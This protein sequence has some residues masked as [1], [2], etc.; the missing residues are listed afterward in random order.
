M[1]EFPFDPK[2]NLIVVPVEVHGES[3]LVTLNMAVDTG[4]TWTIL[5]I[6]TCSIIGAVHQRRISIVTG[7]RVESAHLMT[8]P[9]I[10]AFGINVTNFKVVAHDLPS[11]L[12]VDGLLGMNFLKRVK[13][14]IDFHKN[15][16]KIP[17]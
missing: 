6:K 12:L 5:P 1:I 7:S 15:V 4:A 8:I 2:D 14:T 16:I 17:R 9:L 3:Q 10:K 11:S 13:L